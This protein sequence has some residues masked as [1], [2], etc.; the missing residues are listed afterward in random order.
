MYWIQ[1]YDLKTYK[2]FRNFCKGYDSRDKN[3]LSG[4][5]ANMQK[6]CWQYL[7]FKEYDDYLDYKNKCHEDDG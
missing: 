1:N 4:L 3:S 6:M 2:I 5:S 7:M